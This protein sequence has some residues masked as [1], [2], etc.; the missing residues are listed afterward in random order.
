MQACYGKQEIKMEWL[1]SC[2]TENV[3]TIDCVGVRSFSQVHAHVLFQKILSYYVSRT[4]TGAG[5]VLFEH[6]NQNVC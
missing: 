1:A 6:I 2:R 4:C 5:L 3:Y